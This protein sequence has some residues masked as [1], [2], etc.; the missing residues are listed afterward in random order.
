MTGFLIKNCNAQ[1]LS[2]ELEWVAVFGED[3][4]TPLFQTPHKDV[5]LNQLIELNAKDIQLR[6]EVVSCDLD[7]KGSPHS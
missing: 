5:A 7:E 2:K 4:S 6:A 3:K 1:Y